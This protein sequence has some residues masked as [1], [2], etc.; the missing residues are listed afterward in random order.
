VG[1]AGAGEPSDTEP[2]GFLLRQIG[3]YRLPA[4]LASGVLCV[5]LA[6]CG[7]DADQKERALPSPTTSASTAASDEPV[8]TGTPGG[9]STPPGTPEPQATATPPAG[10][11]GKP[12]MPADDGVPAKAFTVRG[13]V[14]SGAVPS[15]RMLKADNGTM[16]ALY[17]PPAATMK[18]GEH[19][20][21]TV[22]N[23]P[24]PRIWCGE[25]KPVRVVNSRRVS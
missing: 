6:A 2:E 14:Q 7:P 8:P 4:L 17:G 21:V 12:Q 9:N 20:D 5:A 16:W 19:V 22:R 1:R 24:T 10:T 25:G 15:C 23:G 11:P 3:M 13:T 18:V